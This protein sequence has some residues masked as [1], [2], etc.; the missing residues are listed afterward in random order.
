MNALLSGYQEEAELYLRVRRL[1]WRQREMLR[2]GM[3]L[4]MFSDLLEEKEDLL[5]VIA[6]IESE[7]KSAKSLVLS[8]PPAKCPNRRKLE[9]LLERLAETIE[10]IRIVEGNN[11]CLLETIPAA[12]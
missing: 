8:Q 10:E 11:A 5:R 4:S 2:N 7:M 1:T 12:S 3:D 6:E 9:L